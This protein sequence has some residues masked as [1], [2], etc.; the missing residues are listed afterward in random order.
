MKTKRNTKMI[1]LGGI[2]AL[3]LLFSVACSDKDKNNIPEHCQ[4][5][6]VISSN[7]QCIDNQTGQLVQQQ[8]CFN[9]GVNQGFNQNGFNQGFNQNGFNQGFNRSGLSAECS[10][11]FGHQGQFNQFGHLPNNGHQHFGFGQ[12]NQCS[13]LND[14]QFYY[15]PVQTQQGVG[16][17]QYKYHH[18]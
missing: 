9:Q 12:Q 18:Q 6:Y 17:Q 10:Q 13:H 16:C 15:L 3:G 5:R 4:Q 1:K 2:L 8:L 14:H 7:N 11:Y